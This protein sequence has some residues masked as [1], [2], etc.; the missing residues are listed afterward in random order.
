MVALISQNEPQAAGATAQQ[1]QPKSL[2]TQ[3]FQSLARYVERIAWLKWRAVIQRRNVVERMAEYAS[4]GSRLWSFADG[5]AV[6]D[7]S[8]QTVSRYILDHW[9]QVACQKKNE[10]QDVKVTHRQPSIASRLSLYATQAKQ[11]N[12]ERRVGA[13]LAITHSD[14]MNA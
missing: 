9:R 1:R 11:F 12:I 2:S 4:R 6:V 13:V 7:G 14:Y 10:T 5:F 3:K 8:M